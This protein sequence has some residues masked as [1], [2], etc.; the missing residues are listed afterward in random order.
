MAVPGVPLVFVLL[1]R[2]NA[3]VTFSTPV[4]VLLGLDP[5]NVKVPLA[6]LPALFNAVAPPTKPILSVATLNVPVSNVTVPVAKP[7]VFPLA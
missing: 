7:L 1:P 6:P 2:L 4:A 5:P 3:D